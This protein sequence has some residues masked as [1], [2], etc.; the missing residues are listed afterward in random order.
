MTGAESAYA[1]DFWDKL[2]KQ[3][4]SAQAFGQDNDVSQ[5]WTDDF[6]SR[7]YEDYIFRDNNPL[8]D[9]QDC[10]ETGKLKLAEGDLPSAVLLFEAAAQQQPDNP[11][12]WFLLGTSQA[13]NEQDIAAISAL[14]ESLRLDP[15]NIDAILALAAS[16]T[17]ESSQADACYALKDWI[18]SNPKY[19]SGAVLTNLETLTRKVVSSFMTHEL[20]KETLDLYLQA[21]RINHHH[22]AIDPDV[23]SGLGIL[24]N[25]SGDYDK[26]VD[27][28][29]AALNAK[30][31]D[32]LLWNRLGATLANGKVR[33][34]LGLEDF[35]GNSQD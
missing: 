21:A 17:N 18:N 5:M 10:L 31:D 20:H 14:K 4:E 19:N 11:E 3:W 25:L 26:A 32:L 22:E 16:L 2:N 28:F 24:F 30:P 13:K 7:N 6:S 8:K 29:K 23:Q 1:P 34:R 15:K 35:A 12:V 27:C 9:M 33:I